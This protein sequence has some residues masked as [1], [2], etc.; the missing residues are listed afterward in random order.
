[1]THYEQLWEFP[2][3][4]SLKQGAQEIKH[5]QA[6]GASTE[7]ERGYIDA[8]AAFYLADDKLSETQRVQTFSAALAALH[9]R[10]PD[11]VNAA[12]F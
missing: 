3:S 6:A 2:S 11:D 5:A 8:A 7:R 12:A 9:K 1:M 10:S 4:N